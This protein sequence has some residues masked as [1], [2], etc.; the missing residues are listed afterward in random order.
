MSPLRPKSKKT[1]FKPQI[2]TLIKAFIWCVMVW[3]VANASKQIERSEAS[4]WLEVKGLINVEWKFTFC[5]GSL[6]S[7]FVNYSIGDISQAM[8]KIYCYSIA[9]NG[10]TS[11]R[12]FQDPWLTGA[13]QT[14]IVQVIIIQPNSPCFI[15]CN[16]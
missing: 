9:A 10:S 7:W 15:P 1:M 5:S 14:S 3:R 16:W 6:P 11:I 2:F 12:I 4:N 8:H 13:N